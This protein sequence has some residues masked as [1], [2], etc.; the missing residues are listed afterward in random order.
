MFWSY[1][2]CFTWHCAV[3][4]HHAVYPADRWQEDANKLQQLSV[5][6]L[7]FVPGIR[8]WRLSR[9]ADPAYAP[10]LVPNSRGEVHVP[11]STSLAMA[12]GCPNDDAFLSLLAGCLQWD[13]RHRLTADQALQHEWIVQVWGRERATQG[14]VCG[15]QILG[16]SFGAA[17]FWCC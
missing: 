1:G 5:G 9:G 6:C 7:S 8:P 10:L 13:P 14:M 12:M 3:D 11:A 4:I 17:H 16:I 15:F 2:W